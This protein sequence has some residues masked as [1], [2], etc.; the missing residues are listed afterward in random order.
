[1]NISE[2][3]VNSIIRVEVVTSCDMLVTEY[4]STQR[5]VPKECDPHNTVVKT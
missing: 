1:M 5:N 3:L 2:E 4:Q